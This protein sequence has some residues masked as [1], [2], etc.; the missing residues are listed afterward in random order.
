M[1]RPLLLIGTI[2]LAASLLPLAWILR[3]RSVGS[4]QPRIQVVY[5]MDSQP[6]YGAQAA[7]DFFADRRAMRL[8]VPGTVAFGELRQDEHH[9]RGRQGEAWATSFPMDL[10]PEVLERGRER[11][12]IY[13]AVCHG[14]AGRGDGMVARRALQLAEGTWTPPTDITTD[15]VFEQP[16]GSLFN[17]VM[18]GIR[19]MPGY[20]PQISRADRWAIVAYV[21]ALQRSTRGTLEDVPS[22]E[23]S[24]LP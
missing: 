23:R 9:D 5:D 10:T 1:P 4:A 6:R 14:S 24:Q 20:G 12:E 2:L 11:Y 22:D 18:N 7:N 3:E 21:R 15:A 8:P 16:L 17:T 19:N 13:C